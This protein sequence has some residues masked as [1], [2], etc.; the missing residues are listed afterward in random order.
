[1]VSWP[2]SDECSFLTGAVFEPSEPSKGLNRLLA[3]YCFNPGKSSAPSFSIPRFG[4]G[5]ELT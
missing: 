5:F 1:M 3:T 2:G 4:V